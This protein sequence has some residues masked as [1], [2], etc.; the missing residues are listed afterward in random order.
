MAARRRYYWLE[1]IL[2]GKTDFVSYRKKH[3][4]GALLYW[5]RFTE[6]IMLLSV[7]AINYVQSRG[8]SM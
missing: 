4:N 8:V 3:S 2:Q 6:R 7:H 5:T 1:V